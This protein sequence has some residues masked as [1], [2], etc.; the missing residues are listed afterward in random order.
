LCALFFLLLSP[1]SLLLAA[2]A[3]RPNVILFLADDLGW[4]D[5][6]CYGSGF[7]ETPNL[8][9][10]AKQ[11]VRFTDAYAACHVCSPTRASIITGKYPARVQLTDWLPGRKDYPFQRLKNVATLQAL[12]LEETTLAEAL[13]AQGYAT[14]HFGKWHL[15]EDPAGPLAQ[16]FDVQVPRYNK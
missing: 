14:G 12:P 3:A 6:A 8:D 11:S 9:K 13:K 16:G 1:F 5:L 4:R 10:F 15:G 7:Y 2:P